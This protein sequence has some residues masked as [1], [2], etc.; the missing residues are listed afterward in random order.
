MEDSLS[1]DLTIE[2]P[3]WSERL[4]LAERLL[5]QAASAGLTQAGFNEPAL[6]DVLLTDDAEIQSLNRDHRGQDKPTNVLSFPAGETP[7][8]PGQPRPLGS[9]AL[10]L[11][12]VEREAIEANRDLSHH[13]MHLIVH[14][15]LHLIGYTHD[16]EDEAERMEALEIKALAGLGVSNPYEDGIGGTATYGTREP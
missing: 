3:R 10:A 13:F 1:F 15:S 9:I 12:T 6:I 7:A 2:D 14:A 8:I 11:E 16:E 4:N 5:T